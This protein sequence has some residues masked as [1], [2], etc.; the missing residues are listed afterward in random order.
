[1]IIEE[2]KYSINEVFE[3]I[4]EQHLNI[5]QSHHKNKTNIVVD[6]FDIH[7]QSLRYA[8]FYQKGTKCACCGKEGAYFQL[9]GEESSNRRHFNLYAEDGTLM[10]K[11]HIIPKSKGG[12]DF[13]ENLQTMCVDCNKEKGSKCEG[14]E[15]EYIIG[16]DD[17]GKEIVFTTIEKASY[18]LAITK[19]KASSKAMK[20]EVAVKTGIKC[21]INLQTAIE[22]G[23]KYCGY[24]WKKE[25]R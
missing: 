6:G 3:M 16:T 5:Q 2:K 19:G 13:V 21:V 15:I 10:T 24:M 4:G 8:T 1:M 11:D 7:P 9:C 17:K 23:T 12:K 20:K 25:M 18:H 14:H 22:C